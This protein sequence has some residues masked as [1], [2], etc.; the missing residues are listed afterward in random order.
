MNLFEV[1]LSAVCWV[2]RVSWILYSCLSSYLRFT[3]FLFKQSL[4]PFYFNFLWDSY[5]ACIV[6]LDELPLKLFVMFPFILWSFC[7]QNLHICSRL[8]LPYFFSDCLNLPFYLS[9]KFSLQFLYFSALEF[10][11]CFFFR[12]PISFFDIRI[13]FIAILNKILDLFFLFAHLIILKT[14]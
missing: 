4:C 8:C 7:S 14:V 9:G 3:Y 2:S 12:I 13:L 10:M 11:I 6:P 1:I 5:N